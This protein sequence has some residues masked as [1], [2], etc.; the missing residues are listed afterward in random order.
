MTTRW[1][2]PSVGVCIAH[3]RSTPKWLDSVLSG[4]TQAASWTDSHGRGHGVGVLAPQE[5]VVSSTPTASHF[6]ITTSVQQSLS[7]CRT[8]GESRGY[9]RSVPEEAQAAT[10]QV[11][12]EATSEGRRGQ[13]EASNRKHW[14][15]ASSGKD[16][17]QRFRLAGNSE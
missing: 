16:S 7:C 14:L 4:C 8:H 2:A 5:M 9:R 17:R 15:G 12:R 13:A 6:P 1:H 11:K 10:Q 3:M